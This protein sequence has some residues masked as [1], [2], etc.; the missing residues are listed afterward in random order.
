[1]KLTA[2]HGR[3][4]SHMFDNHYSSEHRNGHLVPSSGESRHR[5]R[6]TTILLIS[7]LRLSVDVLRQYSFPNMD[8][9][10]IT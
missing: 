10:M 7:L 8:L 9:R 5:K 4:Q 2:S 1:M 6:L 3:V